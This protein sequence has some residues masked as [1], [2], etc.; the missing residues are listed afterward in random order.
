MACVLHNFS[1]LFSFGIQSML[2]TLATFGVHLPSSDKS[3]EIIFRDALSIGVSP[4]RFACLWSW[5]Q[6]LLLL[7][8]YGVG[9]LLWIIIRIFL[10]HILVLTL[11]FY[12]MVCHVLIPVLSVVPLIA[13]FDRYCWNESQLSDHYIWGKASSFLKIS[14][15]S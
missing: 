12:K 1:F 4:W 3:I 7:M 10:L 6:D 2:I 8:F 15:F 13:I 11:P 9:G 14:H 5:N